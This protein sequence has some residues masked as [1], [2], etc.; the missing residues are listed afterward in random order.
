[1]FEQDTIQYS[2]DIRNML[3]GTRNR[4]FTERL[5]YADS[6]PQSAAACCGGNIAALRI[7]QMDS[8][9]TFAYT[10]DACNRLKTSIG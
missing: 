4:H 9:F 10:Y 8:V 1:M 7:E 3:T 2:Y 5:F 6:L